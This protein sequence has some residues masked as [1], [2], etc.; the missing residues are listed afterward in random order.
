M[1]LFSRNDDVDDVDASTGENPLAPI[2]G[3]QHDT[4]KGSGR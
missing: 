1:R 4:E 3:S 2:T